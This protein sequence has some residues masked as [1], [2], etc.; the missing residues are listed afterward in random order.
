[1]NTR[2]DSPTDPVGTSTRSD[3]PTD[4]VGTS[5]MSPAMDEMRAYPAYLFRRIQK[6][7]GKRVLEIGVG[8]GTYTQMLLEHGCAVRATDIAP[9][10]VRQV[11][12]RFGKHPHLSTGCLDLTDA[13]SVKQHADFQADTIVCLNVLEHIE[14]HQ[15]ALEWLREIVTPGAQFA[16]IVPA[17]QHLYGQMDAEAGHYRRYSRRSA[18]EVMSSAGW[19]VMSTRYLNFVGML[20]WWYHNRVRKDAGLKDARVNQQMKQVDTWLPRF[21]RLTD[22]LLRNLAGL[23]VL[24]VARNE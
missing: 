20:G 14:H 2:S 9:E 8:Y 10:C 19:Q 13:N 1:M 6:T 24:A 17:H 21:A 7:L 4:P 3:A 5:T 15:T 22:P 18:A 23:S 16:L 11:Q 12:E